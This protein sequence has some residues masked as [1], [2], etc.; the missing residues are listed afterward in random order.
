MHYGHLARCALSTSCIAREITWHVTVRA[1]NT[2]RSCVTPFHDPHELLGWNP[3]EILE[4]NVSENTFRRLLFPP[5]DARQHGRDETVVDLLNGI[6][7]R[8]HVY[9]HGSLRSLWLWCTGSMASAQ[10]Y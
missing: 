7:D 6:A 3:E 1:R 8:V 5:R 9:G 10:D 4:P 2:K